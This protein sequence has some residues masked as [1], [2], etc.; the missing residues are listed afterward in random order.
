LDLPRSHGGGFGLFSTR[1]RLSLFGGHLEI[2][3][4][5]GDGTSARVVIP[6]RDKSASR[7]LAP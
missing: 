7:E 1:E 6:A 2:H 3:S 4:S 5:P